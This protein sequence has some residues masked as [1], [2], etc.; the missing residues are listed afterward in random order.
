[1][2]YTGAAA[3]LVHDGHMRVPTAEWDRADSTSTLSLWPP[4]FPAAIALPVYFGVSPIQS[5][6]WINIVSAA[7]IAATVVLIVAAP[8]GLWAGVVA[9]A[10]VFATQAVFDA[11]LSVLSEPLFLALML[12]LL[13]AMVY[14]RDRLILL[15][16]LAT[17][18]VM[19]R[20]AGASAPAAAVV[21]T[22]LD[23]RRD[24]R[25][26]VRHAITVALLPL[27]FVV[28]WFT[29]TALAP[30]R[31]ATPK[32]NV[33]GGWGATM[34]QARDTFAEWL[35]PLLPDGTPQRLIALIVALVLTGFVIATA[36]DTAGNRLRQLRVSGVA[37]ILGATGLLAGCYILVILGSRAFIGGTIPLDWRILVPMIVLMEIAAVTSVGYWWRAYHRPVHLTI[38]ALGLVWFIAAATVTA[39]D[40]MYA[41]TEGSDFAG[42]S[43]RQSPLTAWVRLHARGR[44][45]YSNW[46]PALYFHAHRI[47][48][49]LPDSTDPEDVSGFAEQLRKDHGYV[50]GFDERSPDFIAPTTLARELNLRQVVRTA[51][52]AVWE[53]DSA[54]PPDSARRDSVPNGPAGLQHP[55]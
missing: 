39:N 14:A 29:R 26:R 4:G 40:A 43:W 19:V 50:V 34:L 13:A 35:A 45:V 12:L 30:D 8:L 6:R 38:A 22:L 2:A 36:S 11:H 31:H 44:P 15:G 20:Y 46:P 48:R 10:M 24:I 3:S 28:L 23:S 52:G 7:V 37:T 53:A 1:M 25:T 33:Y 18:A 27:I 55:R 49:E 41:V 17:A 47:A 42:T 54:A 32:L 5:A 16:V 9:A 51:D 21:W